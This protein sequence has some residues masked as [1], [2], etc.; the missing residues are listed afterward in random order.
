ML[1]GE[2]PKLGSGLS[3]EFPKWETK[4]FDARERHSVSVKKRPGPEGKLPFQKGEI[5]LLKT[6]ARFILCP[7]SCP[8]KSANP[9][10]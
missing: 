6:L 3:V 9:L 10:P 1:P 7:H 2:V 4:P 5:P 8:Q